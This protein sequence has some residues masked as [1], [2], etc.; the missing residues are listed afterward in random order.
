[1]IVIENPLPDD[2][3]KYAGRWIAIR[4]RKVVADAETLPELRADPRTRREDV[5]YPV[6]P[7]GRRFL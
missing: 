1:M 7:K 2:T 6:P 3:E 4:G 5:V